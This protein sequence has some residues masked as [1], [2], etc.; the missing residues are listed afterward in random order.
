MTREELIVDIIEAIQNP[1]AIR[2]TV[3]VFKALMSRKKTARK[4][5]QRKHGA[6]WK[7]AAKAR[8]K[9]L[10]S[11][12]DRQYDVAFSNQN[13]ASF[14]GLITRADKHARKAGKLPK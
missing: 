10:K 12:P 1:G 5:L 9:T 14:L 6:G 13:A 2:H 11:N 7:K 8:I 4:M 3:G